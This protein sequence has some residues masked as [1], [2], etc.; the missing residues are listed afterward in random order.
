MEN[1]VV[2]HVLPLLDTIDFGEHALGRRCVFGYETV[3]DLTQIPESALDTQKIKKRGKA[4]R[5]WRDQGFC[6]GEIM[7]KCLRIGKHIKGTKRGDT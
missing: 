4:R 3:T 2:P 7:K 5:L 6:S 1:F